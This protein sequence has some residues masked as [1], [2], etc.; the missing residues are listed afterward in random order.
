MKRAKQTAIDQRGFTLLEVLVAL[1]VLAISSIAVLSQT[2]QSLAQ[3]EQLQL[4]TVALVVAEN[5][6][7]SL[8]ITEQW[9]STGRQSQSV[10]F[11][12]L[13]WQ[14]T[15]DVSSTSEPWLRKIEITVSPSDNEELSLVNLTGYR[16]RY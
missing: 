7:N 10:S 4:K 16:G 5:R 11:A 9:P 12:D 13:Q 3:L 2:R 1:A 8:R 6:L 15:T 14:V